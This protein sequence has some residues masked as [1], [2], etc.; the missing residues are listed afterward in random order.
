MRFNGGF[1]RFGPTH[2]CRSMCKDRAAVRAGVERLLAEEFD[3]VVVAHGQVL[4]SGGR[5]ALRAGFDWLW[6]QLSPPL[7]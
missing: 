7:S 3:R 2:I 4:P 1:D 6:S 5:E